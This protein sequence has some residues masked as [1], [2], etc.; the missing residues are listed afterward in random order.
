MDAFEICLADP[1]L[2]RLVQQPCC[3]TAALPH[4]YTFPDFYQYL[5]LQGHGANQVTALIFLPTNCTGMYQLRTSAPKQGLHALQCITHC[6]FLPAPWASY[7]LCRHSG[8]A[9]TYRTINK[10]MYMQQL[11]FLCLA[12]VYIACL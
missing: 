11:Q 5:N 6:G 1:F 8:T 9:T 3:V 4:C 10:S 2:L 12:Q 7:F